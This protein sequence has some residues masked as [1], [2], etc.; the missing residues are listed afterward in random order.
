MG[1]QP[2]ETAPKDGT[3]VLLLRM[4]G[5]GVIAAPVVDI[6]HWATWYS[7]DSEYTWVMNCGDGSSSADY[8]MPI[9][10]PPQDATP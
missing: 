4:S 9:P 3:D 8:W 1:W 10:P 2:I 6:G 5:D 7:G